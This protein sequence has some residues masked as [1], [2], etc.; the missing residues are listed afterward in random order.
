MSASAHSLPVVR[1]SIRNAWCE[2][3]VLLYKRPQDPAIDSGSPLLLQPQ[4][5]K[6]PSLGGSRQTNIQGYQFER[7]GADFEQKIL[8]RSYVRDNSGLI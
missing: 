7:V 8:A 4:W 1:V 3:V 6:V 5:K 2:Q